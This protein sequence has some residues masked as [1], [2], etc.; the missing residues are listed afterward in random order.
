[1]APLSERDLHRARIVSSVAATAISLACG[2]NYVYSA[3]APQFAD[4]LRLSTT[5][6]NLIGVAG[7]LGMYT[8]GVPIGMVIDRMHAGPRPAVML[9]AL[10]LGLGYLPQKLAYDRGDGSVTLLCMASY[11]TGFGGCMAFAASVKTSAL[12]WPHHRGTATAFPLAAFGLSAFSF[13]VF[14]ELVFPG[15]TG[16]F[17]ATLTVGTF[18]LCFVGFFFLRVWPH[19]HAHGHHH[20]RRRSSQ[21]SYQSLSGGANDSLVESQQLRRTS[22]DA[23]AATAKAAPQSSDDDDDD[24]DDEDGGDGLERQ[25]A[26][27][28]ARTTRQDADVEAAAHLPREHADETSSL[29]SSTASS[30]P[31]E[32]LVQSSVDMDRSHRIDIRGW[33]LLSNGEFWQFFSIMAL[34]AGI[35]LMTINN[36]GHNVNALWRYYDKKVTE[37]FLVSHQQMHVSILSV[38]SFAGRL[39]SGV[40]SDFLVKSLHANRVWCLVVSSLIFFAAQVSAITI[41]DPRLL[42]LV[43]GL[44]GLGYG[45]LFG[46][47]PSIVAESFGIH[48]LSQNWGFLTL[49]PVVSGYV[50]NLFYGTAFDAHSVVGP[51]GERSCPSGLECYRAAYYVTLA[52]C[53][54]GLLV[55]LAVIRHQRA[56][57]SSR[58]GGRD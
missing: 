29:M 10:L 2:T 55:S 15:S 32:V 51:D 38:G 43:S 57:G 23:P 25:G 7:N 16:A 5:Q 52:A 20:R 53:G 31:G 3:W 33:S 19:D 56:Q 41:T 28:A 40:G 11:L 6:S 48:G 45:F 9:G 26:H 24:D 44:S 34:L 30:L 49:S 1:M 42:G 35:G 50:F 22:S 14:G 36:I 39:L 37:E 12:N 27:A 13:S 18:C 21:I 4:K 47:F 58:G 46:V 54:L 17:L 8:M